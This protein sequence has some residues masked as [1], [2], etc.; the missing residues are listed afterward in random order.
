MKKIRHLLFLTFSVTVL[1]GCLQ[2]EWGKERDLGRE[3]AENG[4]L[5]QAILHYEKAL[6]LDPE[7][8]SAKKELAVIKYKIDTE[9]KKETEK[10][11]QERAR[12]EQQKAAADR[13]TEINK[14]VN[15]FK[16]GSIEKDIALSIFEIFDDSHSKPSELIS[17]IE[18]DIEN[19]VLT[20]KAKGKEGWTEESIRLN[21]YEDS[22]AVYREVSKDNRITSAHITLTF[23][24]KD[25]YGNVTD[26][27]VMITW[28]SRETM[29]KINWNNFNYRN[30]LDVVDGKTMHPQ[31][32]Q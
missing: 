15:T 19:K 11:E 20:I 9:K 5:E 31:F 22:T 28:M 1:S 2:A 14:W 10:I 12:K 7:F 3:A 27:D 25:V 4:D 21:F 30:L 26:D 29:E 32:V 16:D 6:E 17:K 18:Y 23:P 8:E 13:K 24:M